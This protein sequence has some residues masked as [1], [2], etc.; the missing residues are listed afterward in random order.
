M[1]EEGHE[2][3]AIANHFI[4]LNPDGLTLMQLLKLSY[5][6][7]GFKLGLDLG[8]LSRELAQAWKYGPVFPSIYHK[9]KYNPPEKINQL[10]TEKG[11]L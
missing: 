10:A 8:P 7:H 2:P 5:I 9:F 1:Q 4:E 3:V 11:F 6:A